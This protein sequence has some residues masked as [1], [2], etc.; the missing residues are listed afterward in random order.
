MGI[1]EYAILGKQAGSGGSSGGGGSGAKLYRHDIGIEDLQESG[2]EAVFTIYNA[3]S[4]DYSSYLDYD[5]DECCYIGS[6]A[7]DAYHFLEE[8]VTICANGRVYDTESGQYA[9]VATI[10]RCGSDVEVTGVSGAGFTFHLGCGNI[11]DHVTQ[12]L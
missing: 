5:Y 2:T 11:N 4:R 1:L 3:D 10:Y 12:I 6:H 7:Q 9:P 8:D